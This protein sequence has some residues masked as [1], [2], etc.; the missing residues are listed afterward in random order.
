MPPACKMSGVGVFYYPI[1]TNLHTLFYQHNKHNMK[2]HFYSLALLIVATACQQNE[3][4][5]ISSSDSNIVYT[6]R[7][8]HATQGQVSFTYPGV[9]ISASFTGTSVAAKVRPNSGYFMVE[10]DDQQPFKIKASE[11]DS[12]L[13]ISTSLS[14][15]EHHIK[16]IYAQEGYEQNPTFYGFIIDA[17]A[18]MLPHPPLPNRRIEFIGNSITCGYGVEADSATEHFSYDTEN[19]YYTY[20]AITARTLNA[21]ELVVARSGI[22]IYKNYGGPIEGTQGLTMPDK[23]HLTL[24]T[25]NAITPDMER[26]DHTLFHP[27]VLCLNLGTNDTSLDTYDTSLIKTAYTNF[28][29]HLRQIYPD[30]KIILLCGSM[31]NG[32]ALTDCQTVLDEVQQQLAD[33]NIFRF[34]FTPQDGSLG[35]GA[36]YHPSKLQQQKMANELIPFVRQITNW[37]N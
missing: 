16:L 5:F 35:Y 9:S 28:I 26:W 22:G 32:R 30:T 19:H 8:S 23:Y 24:F 36:D 20:A 10:L 37:D 1:F 6:G 25:D 33:D 13:N 12:T 34:N 18:Q 3:T 14:Q 11:T 7:V 17:N 29:A 2:L 27:D 4:T 21:Q 31:M 15:G